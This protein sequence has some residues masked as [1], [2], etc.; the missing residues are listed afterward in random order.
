MN[1]RINYESL[2]LRIRKA[3]KQKDLT[4]EQLSEKCGI[5]AAY[6]GNIE[7]G[8]RK[9]SVETLFALASSLDVST[10]SLLIDSYPH[11]QNQLIYIESMLA[12]KDITKTKSFLNTIKVLAEN[13][14][15][16]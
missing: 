10:D 5:S 1:H 3:R 9:L 16:L 4:Q 11:D 13:I 15:D 7:R 12:N 6:L 8:T 2:G 14:D